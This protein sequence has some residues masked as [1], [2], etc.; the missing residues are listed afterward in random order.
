MYRQWAFRNTQDNNLIYRNYL[1][2]TE[3]IS[4]IQ[5][6]SLH[7][8]VNQT[9][10]VWAPSKPAVPSSRCRAAGWWGGVPHIWRGPRATE[11]TGRQEE[12]CWQEQGGS[13]G[14]RCCTLLRVG[15]GN[16]GSR[17]GKLKKEEKVRSSP[18]AVCISLQARF[19]VI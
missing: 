4:D 17:T 13:R 2:Y 14:C 16:H 15:N 11:A 12:H 5:Q 19:R 6:G 10:A 9:Q 18:E 7:E 1:R 3:M 8:Q